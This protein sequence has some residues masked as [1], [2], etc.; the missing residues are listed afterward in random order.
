MKEPYSN[1]RLCLNKVL[2]AGALNLIQT[3][4]AGD[5]A[6]RY[7]TFF[8]SDN[9]GIQPGHSSQAGQDQAQRDRDT[10]VI[11]QAEEAETQGNSNADVL[12]KLIWEELTSFLGAS[13][14][15]QPELSPALSK[16]SGEPES[17]HMSRPSKEVPEI[18]AHSG[19][20]QQTVESTTRN[21]GRH[22]MLADEVSQ[23]SEDVNEFDNAIIKPSPN[24]RP[25]PAKIYKRKKNRMC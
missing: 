11:P 8:L 14:R 7:H 4:T 15:P 6:S 23:D 18:Q 24:L 20:N 16:V 21:P 3:G 17:H 19:G 25:L 13:G 10:R 5:L 1:G 22:S 2:T 9:Q 12:R